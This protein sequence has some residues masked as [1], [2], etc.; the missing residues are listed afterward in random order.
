VEP[1]PALDVGKPA[2][3]GSLS[4]ILLEDRLRMQQNIGAFVVAL[5]LVVFG[6]WLVDRLH[7]YSRVQACLE[8]GHR[9]CVALEIKEPAGR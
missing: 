8:A 6:A 3:P 1:P 5:V 4:A 7:Y 2:Q 9:N